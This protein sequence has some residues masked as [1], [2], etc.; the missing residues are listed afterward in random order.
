MEAVTTAGSTGGI[1]KNPCF[2]SNKTPSGLLH[3]L[4]EAGPEAPKVE[5][6]K[7]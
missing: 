7:K 6:A 1:H 4:P 2:A 5:K 3:P